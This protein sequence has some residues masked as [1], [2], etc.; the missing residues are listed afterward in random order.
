LPSCRQAPIFGKARSPNRSANMTLRTPW[1][2]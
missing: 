2:L 1:K